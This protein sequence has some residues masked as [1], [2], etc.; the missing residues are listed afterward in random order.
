[1]SL[2]DL[3]GSDGILATW[4]R[5][6]ARSLERHDRILSVASFVDYLCL[7]DCIH[8]YY[9]RNEDGSRSHLE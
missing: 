4:I 1:M 9:N 6:L 3:L 7:Y 2:K 5:S 8:A